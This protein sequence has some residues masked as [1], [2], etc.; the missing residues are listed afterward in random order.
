MLALKSDIQKLR[1]LYASLLGSC[2]FGVVPLAVAQIVSL[3]ALIVAFYLCYKWRKS[4]SVDGLLHNHLTFLI[5]TVWIF[6]LFFLVGFV[7][8]SIWFWEAGDHAEMFSFADDFVNGSYF[9]PIE[10]QRA[11][12]A[13]LGQYW[14]ANKALSIKIIVLTMGPSLIYY[15]YRL[16]KGLINMRKHQQIANVSSWF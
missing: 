9:D 5:R 10:A 16:S 3:L 7:P 6:S 15:F 8:G 2:I 11:Y 13:M 1:F 4:T 14:E 12:E